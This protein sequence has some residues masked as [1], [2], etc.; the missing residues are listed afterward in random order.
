MNLLE[1][2]DSHAFTL[3]ASLTLSGHSRVKDLWIFTGSSDEP[4]EDIKAIGDTA[5]LDTP[6]NSPPVG[7]DA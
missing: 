3:L 2:L 4:Q 1:S 5:L 7:S 6:P